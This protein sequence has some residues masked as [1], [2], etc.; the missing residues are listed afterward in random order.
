MSPSCIA[1][2]MV[3]DMLSNLSWASSLIASWFPC[4]TVKDL[5]DFCVTIVERERA[6]LKPPKAAPMGKST[7]LAIAGIEVPPA[8]ADFVI[9]RMS[10]IPMIL[11]NR[12]FFWPAACVL[13]FH[14]AHMPRSQLFF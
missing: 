14:Q 9:R 7:P 11:L 5:E 4:F 1:C 10:T 2:E 8:I 12:F 6:T 13:Q 3:S